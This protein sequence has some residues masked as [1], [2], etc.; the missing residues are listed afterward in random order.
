MLWAGVALAGPQALTPQGSLGET[1]AARQVVD[2]SGKT[3]SVPAR[4][5]RIAD[6]WYAHHVLLMTLGA[7][8]ALSRPSITRKASRGCSRCCRA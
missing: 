6:A 5:L 3:V 7:G 1:S 8:D 2:D 4:P